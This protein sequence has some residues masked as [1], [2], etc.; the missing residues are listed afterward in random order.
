[1]TL[2]EMDVFWEEHQGAIIGA[3]EKTMLG[4]IENLGAGAPAGNN[5][6]A[7]AGGDI[8]TLFHKFISNQEMDGMQPGVPTKAALAGV[9]HRL[10]HPYAKANPARPSFRDTG[11]YL[12]SFRSWM[13]D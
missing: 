12:Q 13:T 11:M 4:A 1:M 8:E 5:A 2:K 3:F 10:A 6:L 9:N 7:E